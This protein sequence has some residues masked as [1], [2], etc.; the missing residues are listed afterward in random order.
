MA[1]MVGTGRG[2]SEGVL[3]RHAEALERLERVDTIVLD[4]TGTL[5]AGRPEVVDT[6]GA[7]TEDALRLAAS[8]EQGSEHPLASAIVRA[9]KARGLALAP[10]ATFESVTG[11]GVAGRVADRDVFVGSLDLLRERGVDTGGPDA[12]D[13]PAQ[14]AQGRTVVYVAI[15]GRLAGRLALA[16]PIKPGAR[17]AL[18]ALRAEGIRI[19]MLTGDARDTAVAVGRELG[20]PPEDVVAEV[21]PGRKREAIRDL[22]ARG[23]VVAMAGDGVN[24]APALAEA[25]VGIA[26][27]TGTDVAMESAGITLVSGDLRALVRARRLSRDTMR[28]IRQNLFLAFAYNVVGVPVAAG[29]LYPVA[30]LLVSPIWASAAMTFSSV[31]VIGNALRLRRG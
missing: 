5:T 31:S 19:V 6:G 1:I 17:E 27:G 11:R 26:M 20:I 29:A 22:Q 7:G 21:L 4:K 16:D 18:D 23:A 14:R 2:A 10:G 8:L 3:V 13:A 28:N 25:A 24:D 15:D 12:D 9:A 30:G